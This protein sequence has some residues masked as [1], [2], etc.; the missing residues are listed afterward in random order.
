M[1][2]EEY[3]IGNQEIQQVFLDFLEDESNSERYLTELYKEIEK[4]NIKRSRMKVLDFLNF[5]SR[6]IDNHHHCENFFTKI[7]TVVAYFS[8]EIKEFFKD[9]DVYNIFQ[10]SP[11]F[12]CQL[13]DKQ[14]ITADITFLAKNIPTFYVLFPKIKQQALYHKP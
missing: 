9:S 11:Q 4:R 6:V 13:I 1:D 14:I 2:I 10:S 7:A 3:L 12:I 5:I 8:K